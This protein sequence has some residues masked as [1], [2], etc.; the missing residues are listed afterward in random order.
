MA[1]NNPLKE[2]WHKNRSILLTIF[3]LFVATRIV[4]GL[5]QIVV[6]HELKPQAYQN[7]KITELAGENAYLS[8]WAVW[9]SE[10]YLKIAQTGYSDASNFNPNK[11][12]TV[13][14]FPLYGVVMML[15]GF[16]VGNNLLAGFLISNICF[17]VSAFL[18]YLLVREDDDEA[19]A[20][21]SVWYLF[22]L[23]FSFIFSAIYPESALLCA[24]LACILMAKKEK[25]FWVG[26]TGMLAAVIKPLGLFILIPAAIIYFQKKN[27]DW[28]SVKFLDAL[29]F[30]LIPLGTAL[31]GMADFIVTGDFLAYSHVQDGA[32]HHFFAD[33]IVTMYHFFFNF[34]FDWT[35]NAIALFIYFVILCF[36]YRKI[37]FAYWLFSFLI[38]AF[39]PFNGVVIG[40]MRYMASLFP[41]VII[42]AKWGKSDNADRAIVASLAIL[43]GT[44]FVFWLCGYWFLS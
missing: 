5:I 29:W 10:W 8:S 9:D 31:V 44:F 12:S 38:M 20:R 35:F 2:H 43:Q 17:I 37:P 27:Y 41:I 6:S 11:Y 33:P 30:G 28:R 25:W 26:L 39:I 36:G 42:L 15:V 21:R 1:Q 4:F 23:P 34:G 13:G 14:F 19:T 3:A 18:L 16:L 40:V 24:W 32:W 22:L 7:W